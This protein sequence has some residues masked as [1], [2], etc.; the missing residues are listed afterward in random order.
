MKNLILGCLFASACF[1]AGTRFTSHCPSAPLAPEQPDVAATPEK[2]QSTALVTQ[3]SET[4]LPRLGAGPRLSSNLPNIS[5]I[6]QHGKE[7]KFVDD[8]VQDRVTCTFF[9]YTNCQGTCPGTVQKVRTLRDQVASEFPGTDVAFIGITLDPEH[10]SADVLREY[11]EAILADDSNPH[12]WHFCTGNKDDLEAL[13]IGLGLYDLNPE[14]DADRTQHAA[15]IVIGNDLQNRWVTMPTGLSSDALTETFLR[16][17][18]QTEKQR[19]S[20]TYATTAAGNSAAEASQPSCCQKKC[21]ETKE[22]NRTESQSAP[23]P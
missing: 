11:S 15:M 18:G 10:D 5:L 3:L 20:M 7:L 14:I 12:P 4:A 13:R 9:F 19:F 23:L 2:A 17:A 16:M 21:C 1:W 6:N 22:T 8:L